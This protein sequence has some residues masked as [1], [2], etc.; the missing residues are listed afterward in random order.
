MNR[1]LL[2]K[3]IVSALIAA[4]FALSQSSVYAADLFS[5]W[6]QAREYDA[7]LKA[8][9]AQIKASN[10]RSF[11]ANAGLG[12]NVS[13]NASA[14]G[15]LVDT[16]LSAH[17]YAFT[18]SLGV[19]MTYPIYRLA[20]L[21]TFEQS[22]LQVTLAQTQLAAAEQ[23]LML[24][25]AQAYFDILAAQDSI[26]FTQAQKRA[27]SEQLASA[28]RNFEVGT[29]TVTDQQEA[30]ARFDLII[31]Q[32][33]AALNDLDVRTAALATLT[34]TTSDKINSLIKTADLIAPAPNNEKA[35]TDQ[36]ANN[37][38]AVLQA[39]IAIEIAKREIS[40]A[41]LGKRPTVDLIGGATVNRSSATVP[42]LQTRTANI[43]LQLSVPIFNGGGLDSREREAV[44]LVNKSENELLASQRIAMQTAR[45]VYKKLASGL[46]QI[47]AL[48]QAE[49]S[50]QLALDSNQ[51]GYKVGVRIN[52]DVL[53][54]QQQLFSTRRDLSRARYDVLVD[55][56]RLKQA[57]G[58][59]NEA[60]L[61]ALSP[62][63]QP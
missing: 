23:D 59:L 62:L 50:S 43:G 56:L 54:A 37:N 13:A 20:G 33:L 30:Q 11:Q 26:A 19:Q 60:D 22:K 28:K 25:V 45:S 34:G 53:N 47:K 3:V 42:N 21:E 27:I 36:A 44:V 6:Q 38:P 7:G 31:A 32:E 24:R 4:P 2:S 39:K 14:T 1:P 5:V 12:P 17:K 8:A 63:L 52:I 10:E 41:S 9:Q 61:K 16:S 18:P 57:S 58:S 29:Q 40:K 51:L 49:K 46:G 35:W 15:T 55:G 48:Q